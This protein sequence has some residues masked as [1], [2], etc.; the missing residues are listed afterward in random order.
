MKKNSKSSKKRTI[1]INNKKR[2][3]VRGYYTGGREIP[4]KWKQYGYR[5]EADYSEERREQTAAIERR[6]R[7]INRVLSNPI[8]QSIMMLIMNPDQKERFETYIRENI[9][10]VNNRETLNQM[11]D[12][13]VNFALINF[14]DDEQRLLTTRILDEIQYE[15]IRR[16]RANQPFGP[17]D[18]ID[19]I[20]RIVR[21]NN[22]EIAR[23]GGGGGYYKRYRYTA[24]NKSNHRK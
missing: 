2:S 20:E 18:I 7:E 22:N 14:L 24:K 21:E 17:L 4:L 8:I 19:V 16:A 12:E 5:T 6:E 15:R 13:F 23:R 11:I 9:R 10:I 3:S 1:K